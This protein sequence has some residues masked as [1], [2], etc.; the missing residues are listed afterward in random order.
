MSCQ[1]VDIKGEKK[2]IDETERE[3]AKGTGIILPRGRN[4]FRKRPTHSKSVG[5]FSSIFVCVYYFSA[6]VASLRLPSDARQRDGMSPLSRG[7]DTGLCGQF[8]KA[9]SASR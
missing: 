3:R 1:R 5:F 9:F 2:V 6:G 7:K 8:L 4:I